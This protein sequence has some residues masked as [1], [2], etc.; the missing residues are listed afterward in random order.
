MVGE[1]FFASYV[2]AMSSPVAFEA[3]CRRFEIKWAILPYAADAGL[4]AALAKSP[5]WSLVYR[6]HLAVIL[7]HGESPGEPIDPEGDLPAAQPIESL[8]GLGNAPRRGKIARWLRG[9]IEDQ[10]FPVG[11]FN[12]GV[13]HYSVGDGSGALAHWAEAIRESDGRY[14]EIYRNVGYVLAA[15]G[16]TELARR[17]FE[18]AL[19]DSPGDPGA[20]DAM[21]RMQ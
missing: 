21:A 10:P 14:G 15:A 17:C 6:D 2:D 19:A 5:S 8:P 11:H 13:F 7:V 1:K 12:R 18:I 9:A 4:V 16:R 20:V 3:L